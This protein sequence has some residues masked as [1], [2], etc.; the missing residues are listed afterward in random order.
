[1]A[2]NPKQFQAQIA[3]ATVTD[4]D[5][6]HAVQNGDISAF[7]ELVNR[8]DRKLLRIA[9]HVTRNREDAQDAVQEAFLKA[10]QHLHQF[11][12]Q[13]QFST[14]MIRITLNHALMKVRKRQRTAREISMDEDFQANG[15]KPLLEIADWAPNPEALYRASELRNI[16]INALG[17]LRPVLRTVFVLRDI[18]QLSTIEAAQAMG[19]SETAVKAR[20]WRARRQLRERLSAYFSQPNARVRD[21]SIQTQLDLRGSLLQNQLSA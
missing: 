13:S 20:L 15:D 10:F 12:E 5:L 19:L 7:E 8:Y 6:V 11:R 4:L 3:T 2:A 9:R 1:M 16:L 21:D 14:W 18:E 17:E